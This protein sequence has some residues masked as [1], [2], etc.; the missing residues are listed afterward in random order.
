M[1]VKLNQE[2][3]NGFPDPIK[4][5]CFKCQKQFW[6][7]FVVPQQNYNLKNSWDYWTNQK[8]NKGKKICNSCLRKFYLEEKKSYFCL[9]IFFALLQ[10]WKLYNYTI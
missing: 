2:S 4:V 8:E 6:I 5:Y 10:Y 3:K 9:T 7:K 1:R